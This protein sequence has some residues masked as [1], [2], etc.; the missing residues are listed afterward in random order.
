M[1]YL[2]FLI[3]FN[4]YAV[5]KIEVFRKSNNKLI[6]ADKGDVSVLKLRA[7]M[8]KK[9]IDISSQDFTII[10][11]DEKSEKEIEDERKAENQEIKNMVSDI[12]ASGKPNWEKKLLKKLIKEIRE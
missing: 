3:C 1:K 7:K 2:I 11:S 5:P 6:A 9:G 4:V 10:E 12:N 8:L